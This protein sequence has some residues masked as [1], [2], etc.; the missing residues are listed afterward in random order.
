MCPHVRELTFT[1]KDELADAARELR[2]RSARFVQRA[3]KH[4]IDDGSGAPRSAVTSWTPLAPSAS[5]AAIPRHSAIPPVATTGMRS[6]STTCGSNE[7]RPIPPSSNG[8]LNVRR[9]PPA[10]KPCAITASKPPASLRFGLLDRSRRAQQED[11]GFLKRS[12]CSCGRQTEWKLTAAA[13]SARA[14]STS[15]RR[16]VAEEAAPGLPRGGALRDTVRG[17]LRRGQR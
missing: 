16:T 3:P 12:A 9:C 6:A 15:R 5:A 13:A 2:V 7:N 1:R 14:H 8:S 17:A 4:R 10:S 11:A